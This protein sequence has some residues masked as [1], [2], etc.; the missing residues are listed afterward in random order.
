[1]LMEHGV[2]EVLPGAAFEFLRKPRGGSG[3]DIGDADG[4]EMRLQ[5]GVDD[6][7]GCGLVERY[8]D[9]VTVDEPSG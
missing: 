4:D 7:S 5:D 3:R 2:A 9:V 8:S 6:G 1:M